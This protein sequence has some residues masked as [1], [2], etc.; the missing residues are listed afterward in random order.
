MPSTRKRRA[1]EKRARQSDVMS[2]VENLDIM[3]GTY[4]RKEV[5]EL[6]NN[7]EA[8]L[9]L[10]PGRR[11]QSTSGTIDNFRSLLNTN[12]S[13][14]SEITTATNRIINSEISSQISRKLEEMKSDLNSY[15]L[16]VINFAIE[17][18]TLPSIEN[19]VASKEAAKN[20]K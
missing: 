4:S 20:T 13:E 6:E 5:A 15:I 9:D 7:S 17:E 2:D 10:E 19:A 18:K 16:E 1:R 8:G 14:N 12:L 3:L 11:Q